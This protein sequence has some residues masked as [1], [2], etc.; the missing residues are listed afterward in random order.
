MRRWS[1]VI[2]TTKEGDEDKIAS[3]SFHDAGPHST[4]GS[5]WKYKKGNDS[6][7]DELFG[8]PEA[9]PFQFILKELY[10]FQLSNMHNTEGILTLLFIV[11]KGFRHENSVVHRWLKFGISLVCTCV[12]TYE[13]YGRVEWLSKI[14]Y[15]CI[16]I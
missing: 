4:L 3:V 6:F 13:F 15:I 2:I 11:A 12:K 7:R 16:K 8:Y 9:W 10:Y 14:Y 1:Q 5:I